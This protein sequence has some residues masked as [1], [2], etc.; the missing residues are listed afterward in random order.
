MQGT[1]SNSRW[2]KH[3]TPG[4]GIVRKAKS[5]ENRA[6]SGCIGEERGGGGQISELKVP[7]LFFFMGLGKL[8]N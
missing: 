7:K 3:F 1:I 2:G 6:A 8:K 4:E 5:F